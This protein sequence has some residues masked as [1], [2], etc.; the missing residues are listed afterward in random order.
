MAGLL[1][2]KYLFRLIR[3]TG[4]ELLVLILGIR[5]SRLRAIFA[6]A[7]IGMEQEHRGNN[8]VSC[9]QLRMDVDTNHGNQDEGDCQ[10]VECR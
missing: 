6:L 3:Q 10:L 8:Q 9:G 4:A 7:T 1:L 5:M 2:R